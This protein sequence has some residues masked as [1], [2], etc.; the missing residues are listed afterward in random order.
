MDKASLLGDI[1]ATHEALAAAANGLDDAALGAPAPGMAG[2][3]RK[4]VLAHVE[5]WTDHS[6]RIVAAL[7]AGETPYERGGPWSLDGQNA[8]ILADNRD[9]A[10]A[11]VRRGEAEAFARLVAAVESASED[12][13]FTVGRFTW[14][15]SDEPLAATVAGDSSDHYREHLAQLEAPRTASTAG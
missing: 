10:A 1:S 6:A 3:T 11:D 13:L 2:W 15:E 14:L 4:D 9:R 8:R 12:E 5:W 7:V